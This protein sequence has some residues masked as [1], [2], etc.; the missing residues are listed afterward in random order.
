MCFM[1]W[2]VCLQGG[3]QVALLV[4]T[5]SWAW[6]SHGHLSGPPPPLPC[7]VAHRQEGPAQRLAQFGA[8]GCLR[9]GH[10]SAPTSSCCPSCLPS[11]VGGLRWCTA[12]WLRLAEWQWSLWLGLEYTSGQP[13]PSDI[14]IFEG[15]C[16][17]LCASH[18]PLNPSCGTPNR[19]SRPRPEPA[20]PLSLIQC[21]AV[22]PTSTFRQRRPM[23]SAKTPP[24]MTPE[25]KREELKAALKAAHL[26]E[27]LASHFRIWFQ[28][29]DNQ[30]SGQWWFQHDQH[31]D[32]QRTGKLRSLPDVVK[33]CKELAAQPQ[34][35][36]GGSIAPRPHSL[37][38]LC[39]RLH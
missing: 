29:R 6:G 38:D 27:D 17:T 11:C 25:G 23:A 37:C 20:T 2:K 34:G 28:P 22:L 8:G 36:V 19:T 21:P 35:Q 24:P 1:Q 5:W 18:L 39:N 16:I 12:L 4:L 30:S 14:A 10:F 7:T 31:P 3:G 9:G 13:A 32:D 26:A 15:L 33:F